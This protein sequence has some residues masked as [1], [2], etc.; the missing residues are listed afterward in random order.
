MKHRTGYSLKKSFLAV[1]VTFVFCIIV[2]LRTCPFDVF[3][4]GCSCTHGGLR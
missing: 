2:F 4:K 3:T 1:T